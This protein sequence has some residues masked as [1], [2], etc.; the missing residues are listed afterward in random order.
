MPPEV[1]TTRVIRRSLLATHS[2]P[3]EYD[4]CAYR[5][6]AS[7][8]VRY[9]LIA[10]AINP[11]RLVPPP[12][13][14]VLTE[15]EGREY[16]EWANRVDR[17]RTTYA[18]DVLDAV[19]L[20]VRD[21]LTEPDKLVELAEAI[22]EW[23]PV[24][25]EPFEGTFWV[26]G[27]IA[28][29]WSP[30]YSPLAQALLASI[31][32]DVGF[33]IG[34]CVHRVRP[35]ARWVASDFPIPVQVR[36]GASPR[37][38][39]LLTLNPLRADWR[40]QP[41]TRAM[42]LL[43]WALKWRDTDRE[44]ALRSLLDCYFENLS[45]EPLPL[46]PRRATRPSSR[47]A[48]VWHHTYAHRPDPTAANGVPP[49]E[50]VEVVAAYR[51]AGFFADGAEESDVA[52]AASLSAA[53]REVAGSD[54]SLLDASSLDEELLCLDRQRT[55]WD[56][57]EF[58]VGEGNKAYVTVVRALAELSDGAFRPKAVSEHWGTGGRVRVSFVFDGSRHSITLR[59]AGDWLDPDLVVGINRLLPEDG[60]RFWFYDN[61][62]QTA[63]VTRATKA[64]VHL[65]ESVRP[66]R[67]QSLPPSWWIEIIEDSS[68]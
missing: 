46:P 49:D 65:L 19:G 52:L 4:L 58:D 14:A 51:R 3:E 47:P 29:P 26:H 17:D 57:A 12:H 15:E 9:R 44:R 21:V 59:D 53:W 67:L 25:M 33:V 50:V 39:H 68:G 43:I 35:A 2:V 16:M 22:A 32:H 66:V 36:K 23:F 24:L 48:E 61:G 11:A 10:F 62:G 28:P 63:V 13:L 56:D 45:E 38:D 42:H 55:F 40:S 60:P 18:I 30:A 37:G 64:E 7:R 8:S 27:G 54:G 6:E 1:I 34:S 41:M 5:N 20:P 31:G